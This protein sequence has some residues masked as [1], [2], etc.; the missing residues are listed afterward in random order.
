MNSRARTCE[1]TEE[2][3]EIE[4][5][6]LYLGLLCRKKYELLFGSLTTATRLRM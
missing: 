2:S 4:T 3:R 5:Q 6:V 1:L